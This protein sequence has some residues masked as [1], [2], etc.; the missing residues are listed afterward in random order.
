MIQIA[1]FGRKSLDAAPDVDLTGLDARKA[2][3]RLHACLL[4]EGDKY[5]LRDQ[6]SM[7]G[8]FING[9]RIKPLSYYLLHDGDRIKFA[10]VDFEFRDGA[11]LFFSRKEN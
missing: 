4:K 2:V 8:T 11:I 10:D 5:Y 9:E 6:S 7:N 3:S 1:S